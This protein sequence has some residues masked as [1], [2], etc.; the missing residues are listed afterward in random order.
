M[1]IYGFDWGHKDSKKVWYGKN[2]LIDPPKIKDGDIIATENIPYYQAHKLFCDGATIYN[3][4]CDMT[5]QVRERDGIEKTDENDAKILYELYTTSPENFRE[6][7]FNNQLRELGLLTKAHDDA[8]KENVAHQNRTFFDGQI[9]DSLEE[10]GKL[11]KRVVQLCSDNINR[12]VWDMDIAKSLCKFAFYENY[13][14]SKKLSGYRKDWRQGIGAATLAKIMCVIVDPFRFEK[15]TNL[16]SYAGLTPETAQPKRKGKKISYSIRLKSLALQDLAW[17][18]IKCTGVKDGESL[19]DEGIWRAMY[20]K[21]VEELF[22]RDE[23]EFTL[24]KPTS[25]QYEV[26]NSN[27][28]SE[29][30]RARKRAKRHVAKKMLIKIWREWKNKLREESNV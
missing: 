1:A 29:F 14:G 16:A 17:S 4:N 30:N 15:S 10:V 18:C 23:I 3:C 24:P 20:R 6:R 19:E 12:K 25:L 21:K 5:M 11:K 26:V 13:S 2:G 22:A 9:A 8:T 28:S 7:P 27:Q